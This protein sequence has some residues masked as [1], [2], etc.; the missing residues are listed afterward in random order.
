[1]NSKRRTLWSRMFAAN[2]SAASVPGPLA[3]MVPG[4]APSV[5]LASSMRP[6]ALEQRFMFDGAGAVDAAHAAVDA[7]AHVPDAQTDAPLHALMAE[8]ATAA[9]PAQRNEVVFVDSGVKDYAQIMASV[10]PGTEVVLLD[11]SRD[12]V[13][14]MAQYLQG[15]S[16]ID[17]IHI[18][19]HGADG[20]VRLGATS[21]EQS[22]LSSYAA[23]LAAIGA[24]LTADGDILLYGCNIAADA[25]GQ[26]FLAALAGATGADV[27]A[28]N[29]A[30]GAQ[31][32]G[33]D[34][35]LERQSGTI[36]ASLPF[37]AERIAGYKELLVSPVNGVTD[38]NGIS[39]NLPMY[40]IGS[41]T[42]VNVA[43]S[44]WD[45]TARGGQNSYINIG[46]WEWYPGYGKSIVINA[47]SFNSQQRSVEIASNSGDLF[48]LRSFSFYNFDFGNGGFNVTGYR[49]GQ[50]VAGAVKVFPYIDM[51][52]FQTVDV[53]DISGFAG[54][55]SFIV[56]LNGFHPHPFSELAIDN[57]NVMNV[58]PP[59]A[60]PV[61]AN[62]NG[63]AVTFVEG[64]PPV[65]LDAGANAVV[66][67]ADSAHFNGGSVRVAVTGGAVA[68]E[69]VL[70]IN[71]QGTAA[72]QISVSGSDVLYGG[73]VI[74][75]YSGGSHGNPLVVELN[76][77]ASGS[78]V[79][80][81]VQSLGYSNSNTT[82]LATG[83]RM[84]S[85]VVTDDTGTASAAAT[86]TVNLQ[87]VNDAPVVSVTNTNPTFTEDG[88][89]VALFSGASIDTVES[90]QAIV[91]MT[92][93]VS[94]LA[95][96]VAEKLLIDGTDVTL[97]NGS[98]FITLNNGM[99]VSVSVNSGTA[100][101]TMTHGGLSAATAQTIV[102]NIAYRNDSNAPSG[103][104]RSVT[105][106]DVRDSGGTAH[107]GLDTTS[108]N[109][110]S[111]VTL[112]AVNDAPTLSGVPYAFPATDENSIS[113]SVSVGT[114]L[115]SAGHADADSGAA[116]GIAVTFTVGRGTWQYSTD[117]LTWTAFGTVST[118][119]ALLLTSSSLVRYIPD[120]ANG[121]HV[122][123]IFRAWDR[124]SGTAS[125]NGVRSTADT[126]TNGGIT[127]YSTGTAE[128][129]LFV[130]ATNDA[131]VIVPVNPTL[132][133]LSDSS[134]NNNGDAV[135]SLLGGAAD[136]DIGALKGVAITGL[137]GTYGTW[138]YSTNNGASWNDIGAVSDAKALVLRPAD[139]VRFVPDGIHSETA[140]ITYRAW[141][142]TNGTQGGQGTKLDATSLG[143]TS[144][145]STGTDTASVV[146]TA[147]NDA[148]VITGTPGSTG[149]TEGD[150]VVSTPVV[151]DASITL[152]DPDGPSIGSA[153]ARVTGNY[154]AGQDLLGFTNDNT[155]LY[156]D[157]AGSWNAATGTLTL[158]SASGTATQA[159]F[160][161]ALR[162]VTFTNLSD[163]PV[164]ATRTVSF[165][166]NDGSLDSNAVTREVTITAVNDAPVNNVPGTQT[167]LQDGTL[168]FN[169]ASGNAI[170][171]SDVDVGNGLMLLTVVATNGTISADRNIGMLWLL[172]DGVDDATILVYGTRDGL[173]QLL[174]SLSFKPTAGFVGAADITLTVNDLGG[175]GGGA[176]KSDVD[177]IA[178]T[179]NP[180]NPV[181][182]SVQAQG[183][184][185]TVK[186]GDEVLISVNFDQAIN[187]DLTGGE[188]TLQLETGVEDRHAVFV[189]GS[190]STL[191]FRYTVQAGDVTA[192]LDF[193]NTA[194]L[195]LNGA[196]LTNARNDLAVTTLPTVGSADSLG[197]RSSIVVDGVV[198][199]VGSVEV[200]ANGTYIPGQPL[201][202]TVNFSEAMTVSTG[203]GTPRIEVTLD[204]GATAWASYV[205]GSG[206]GAL[207]FRLGVTAGQL[208]TNGIA[209]GSSVQL[210]GGTLRDA[211]GNDASTALVNVGATVG[212]LVDGVLPTATITLS[213]S[214]LKA[215]ETALVTIAFSEAVTGLDLADF[216]VT[217]GMLS[218]LTAGADGLFWTATF[219]PTGNLA[220][221][222][223]VITLDNTGFSDLAG[224]AG[225]STTESDNYVI[226]TQRPTAAIVVAEAAL[227]LGENSLVSITFSEAVTGFTNDDLT[228]ANGA[229]SGVSS[230]DGGKTWTATFTPT[231]NVTDTTNLITLDN[232]G[233][234]DLAGNTG[235][236]TTDSNNYAIDTQRPT[237]SIVVADTALA[238]GESSLV[239]I[240]FS[241]A[242]TGLTNADLSVANGTLSAVSSSDG[243][244]TWMATFTPSAHVT[245][246]TN[247]I[248]LDNSGV[249]DL[250]GNTGS[251][252]T[253][254]NNYVIDTQRPTASIVVADTALAA[255]ESSLVT[256]SFSEAVTGFTNA[257]LSV[258]NGTLSAVGSADGGK[259]WSAMFTPTGNVTD[260]TN[261]I[262]L[263]NSGVEDLAG[264]A[265]TG[266]T[267]SNNYAIDTLRPT[268][269]IVVADTALAVGKTSLVT[270]TFSE[271]VN[272]F[273]N[274]DLTVANGTLST[275]SSVD[276]G[277][278]WT[279]TFT[280]T[281]NVTDTT[282]LITLDNSGVNDLA[283]NAGVGTTDSNNYA[284][285][286]L[287][288]TATIVVAD[289]ALAVGEAS[290][291]TITISEKVNGF[292]NDDLTVA[293]GTLSTVSSVDGG[294]TWTATFT[295]SS[296]VTDTTN[297]ITLDYSGVNDLAG[298]AGV[299]TTDSNNYAIDT[300]RPTA[301]IVV[302]DTAL[303]AGESSLVTISFSEVV[304]GFSNDD[305]TVANG[306][307]SAVSSADG[308]KTWT[309][310]F[311]PT[312]NVTDTTNV[313]TLDNSGVEDLAGNAGTGTTDSNNYAIDTL[314]P[315]ATIVVADTALAVGET[316]LVTITFSEPVTGLTNADLS[317][318]NGTLSAV[319]SSDGG[320]TWTATFTP[321][322]NV[323]DT[324]NL[325]TLDNSGVNDLAGNAGSGTTASNNYAID[326]VR[327]TA[328]IVVSDSALAVGETSLVTI[329]FSEAVTGLTNAD[330]SVANGTLSAVSSSDGGITWTA[331][332]T[333]TAHVT[334]TTNLITLHNSGVN[335]LAGNAG[336]GTTD[337]N[338]YAIDTLRPTATI[339]VADTA[340]AVG[341]SALVTITFSEA[342]TGLTNADL[343]VANGTLSGVSSADGG[344]T[345]TAMF[346]P[347][348]NVTDTT[349]VITLDNSGVNDLAGNA[350]TGTTD[351]NN[352]AIDTLRPT[353]TIVVADSALR[354]GETSLVTITFSEPVTGFANADL[355]VANGTLSAV[356]S[357]D[358]GVTW[359]ATFTPTAHVTDT[360]NLITLD[361]TGVI[362]Q[363]GNTGTGTTDSNNY[364]IDTVRPTATIVVADSAL[365]VGETSLVTITFSEAV[366]GLTNADLTV[367]NGT[368]SAVSSSDGG[369]TW[370]ATFTPTA[371]VTDATNL[372][373]LANAG[374]SDLA[375]NTG[376][377]STDSNNYAIDTVRPT[378]TIVVADG[379]L[380]V[381]ETSLVT[382]T[383]SEAVKGFTNADLTVAN[384]ALS[385]V[386]SSDGGITW[387]ATF[388]PT[389][390]VTDTTNLITLDNTG[391]TDLAGNAGTG[392]TE[393]NNYAID[394]ARPTATITVADTALR[395]GESS[396]VT[397]AFSEAVSGLALSDFNVTNGTLAGL[398]TRDGGL[399]WTATFTP[400]ANVEQAGNA[401]VLRS[402]TVT[403]AAGNAIE[404]ETG[405][406]SFAID[407]KLPTA[408]ITVAETAVKAGETTLVTIAFSEAV[409][410]LELSHFNV[411][412]GTLAGLST[413]DGGL[414]WTA[415]F[416]PGADVEQGGNAIALRSG[417]VTDAA[418]NAIQGETGSNGFAIDTLLPTAS[419]T[420]ADTAVKAGETTLVTIAFSEAVSGLEL[421]DF[422][423]PNGTLAGL[424][425][426]DGG[427][428][429]TATFTPGANVEQA[430]NL[431]S[432]RS[433]AV[434]DAAGNAISGTTESNGYA[435]DTQL[436]TATITVNDQELLA[437]ETAEVTIV[438]SEAVQG[439]DL[440]DFSVANGTLSN[441]QTVDG[442]TWT[443]TLTPLGDVQAGANLIRLNNAGYTD[444]SG[445]SGVGETGS[446]SYAVATAP[447]PVNVVAEPPAEQPAMPPVADAALPPA[448]AGI[449]FSDAAFLSSSKPGVEF[450]SLSSPLAL[451]LAG[452]SDLAQLRV[453]FVDL[454]MPQDSA[455]AAYVPQQLPMA[456]QSGDGLV[457]LRSV[458]DLSISDS[459]RVQWQVPA[460]VFGHT[461]PLATVSLTMTLA[462]G[463][464]L[465]AWVKF[466]ARTGRLEVQVPADFRGELVLQ[467]TARDDQGKEVKTT[468]KLKPGAQVAARA[469]V[470]EQFQRAALQRAG[471]AA[472]QRLHA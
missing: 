381:G 300:Q 158:I 307:L 386:S 377:G 357:S 462:D 164:A 407:T 347:T 401:I 156:G 174:Q 423:V 26:S 149:W 231:V 118:S 430:G 321:G 107:L 185:R 121:E 137:T 411:P 289:I 208:D 176:S 394:T 248:T 212:I 102:N 61:V 328:T 181:V 371:N 114:I 308:G 123:L 141:D 70:S 277:K 221:T 41:V 225:S 172:G 287:R 459:G 292:S 339:V 391:V 127:A 468:V 415:T 78:A 299:G 72:G 223:N 400:G 449:S 403:D 343:S 372:I 323:T 12:G 433:G 395:A 63:D 235:V 169:D 322:G 95:N 71:S 283:G 62:L 120:G 420:V 109:A 359:T 147:V 40:G 251:G 314:R 431:I 6:L 219:T 125:T 52:V 138:Q 451:A 266:T 367:A 284:I 282:N 414:T 187:F 200:P 217:G 383:F 348:G 417:T 280:P 133:S 36:E 1:M 306:T 445:N 317:V 465:P 234:N 119:E 239:T 344:K 434:T 75:T 74:G 285:D 370:T 256:I 337:S 159:Q 295:P 304:N 230:S 140:T 274:D 227:A 117:G 432:L 444:L 167:V 25:Q 278:T 243:G 155:S 32:L 345:W 245:D 316:S 19:S 11:A 87:A 54:I 461:N 336:A 365:A 64:N 340:L 124:T 319:S 310:M 202:F 443:A 362:D 101:V 427:L 201:D 171:I 143:G 191:T 355:S 404:G 387:T 204:D 99:T 380:A 89:A 100:T 103:S 303:A 309:A 252:T 330:L 425:T 209:V 350:G 28:S 65:T 218:H 7:A 385:A 268:A 69:D 126:T 194:A 67:D 467:L 458:N 437:G 175:M 110:S 390:H 471:N 418:G 45:I 165:M 139:R 183:P 210:N 148:P 305:L 439:L 98:N 108:P 33:G 178:I 96:G 113:A 271:K 16:G 30:T 315:T 334:D 447:V 464:P 446:D 406:N 302:A 162:A 9:A 412:N 5:G 136:V 346:T 14:Q 298:N 37:D 351:S 366:T 97:T 18:V 419:I 272:G 17:A 131:P 188:P 226:D 301:S 232:S 297:V 154:M 157:I 398:S 333:P 369:I 132:T 296:N 338:N 88:S 47:D 115:A 151:V 452:F 122:S 104:S 236:G 472:A 421:A 222:L 135:I 326:T 267:D 189:A 325:I 460:D 409:S 233:V 142:Q 145:F 250:A 341:E 195:Q 374:V 15:R 368:L 161:Q 361:N 441:L 258:A 424:S 129:T 436:P 311:T 68:G 455:A 244:K 39:S 203:G 134:I 440:A 21:L 56:T 105:L 327:P 229:L 247:L 213:D 205:S 49:D 50:A 399:T 238:A 379:A 456:A 59:V 324:S 276:G 249:N 29:N 237:A 253:D 454:P 166:V 128:A 463:S 254:S 2:A 90:G 262:T 152:S 111:I 22:N 92:I 214:A 392:S 206:T 23:E 144:A 241:E 84:L 246:T 393:S 66:T 416:T 270:I 182:T 60:A 197:G 389:A 410:G 429:W 216:H 360:T 79:T 396:L 356:S 261:V 378:A 318:A 24:G 130:N 288:P 53:S 31:A 470:A 86:V 402:G 466:D 281:V 55:D 335:D 8:A 168:A 116:S 265:G 73:V 184:D 263:D 438:F 34:W 160:Q 332:F 382:I 354:I 224:N 353:T 3:S 198:P 93:R 77:S 273:G 43:G 279:A 193:L 373:T 150:N 363:A 291:V 408:S 257:D 469:G 457:L 428:T 192:D 286:T 112:V 331:T 448:Q 349:N 220:S 190:G 196:L 81:L 58:R 294:K 388:T 435:I 313:I 260:T 342:V 426:R 264:N 80:A 38:F 51:G 375:G 320:V 173:N 146:V 27:A 215:G 179:V 352:Y 358:G 207:V 180:R 259:T 228:V 46:H 170:S 106:A 413:S 186:I 44:G 450:S 275:V 269:T 163:T 442:I 376:A 42:A 10:L 422:N 290:L 13:Q 255:G 293:N 312:G 85:V 397:I 405:S 4:A 35:V 211:A 240:S 76:A 82:T 384:G 153:T 20:Q 57:I 199:V 453:N 94:D 48:D 364:A 91:Q 83:A 329:S 242:V 177:T